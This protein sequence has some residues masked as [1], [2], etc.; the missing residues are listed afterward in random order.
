M[1]EEMAKLFRTNGR[2]PRCRTRLIEVVLGVVIS[3][4]DTKPA[5]RVVVGAELLNLDTFWHVNNT[6]GPR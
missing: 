6:Q 2:N 5:M 3:L 1:V 4:R